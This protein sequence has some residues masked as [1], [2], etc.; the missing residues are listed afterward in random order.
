MERCWHGARAPLLLGAI[1]ALSAI[2]NA[3]CWAS[4]SQVGSVPARTL[5]TGGEKEWGTLGLLVAQFPSLSLQPWRKD[6]VWVLVV[7]T[8]TPWTKEER[9][10]ERE[11]AKAYGKTRTGAIMRSLRRHGRLHNL[12]TPMENKSPCLPHTVKLSTFHEKCKQVVDHLGMSLD[13][14]AAD[15]VNYFSDWKNSSLK[16]FP[17]LRPALV[18]RNTINYYFIDFLFRSCR[19]L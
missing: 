5:C 18:S 17:S 8:V 2:N 1:R 10:R 3:E 14:V 4:I 16:I 15:R 7:F 19:V 12:L 11:R 6:P 13:R 9:E